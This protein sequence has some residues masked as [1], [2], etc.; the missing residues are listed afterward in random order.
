MILTDTRLS[1]A[2]PLIF[3]QLITTCLTKPDWTMDFAFALG[4]N[5]VFL[6]VF[7]VVIYVSSKPSDHANHSDDMRNTCHCRQATTDL[8]IT[9]YSL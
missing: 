7:P 1:C 2:F 9:K 8:K 4:D 5:D 3:L 6:S